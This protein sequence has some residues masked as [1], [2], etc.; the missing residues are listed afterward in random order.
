MALT[1]QSAVEQKL[2]W[3]ITAEPE[4]VITT[5]IAQAQALIESE[6]G[7]PIES[8]TYEETFDGGHRTLFLKYWPVT[9]VASITEDGTTLTAD[10]EY[11][12]YEDGRVVRVSAGYQTRWYTSKLQSIVVNYTGGLK[13]GDHDMELAHLDNLCAEVVARAFRNGAASAAIP[14]GVGAGGIQS[15]SLDGSDSVTFT[16]PG[17]DQVELGGGLSRFVYL[18]EDE[19]TQAHRY[20]TVPI[21]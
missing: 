19:K 11:K 18:L 3:D 2:Q 14:A 21:A 9:G 1:T 20:R 7:R 10:T 8:D 6:I 17:G 5:L 15:V 4:T 16:T 12:W 13:A